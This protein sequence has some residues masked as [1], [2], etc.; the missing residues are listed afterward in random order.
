MGC[1]NLFVRVITTMAENETPKKGAGKLVSVQMES[2]MQLHEVYK[3]EKKLF[4]TSHT[5]IRT[6]TTSHMHA[7]EHA[8]KLKVRMIKSLSP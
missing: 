7:S 5:R 6:S 8:M 4:T 2:Q 1:G 3:R